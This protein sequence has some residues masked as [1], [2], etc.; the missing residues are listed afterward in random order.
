[1]SNQRAFWEW[2]FHVLLDSKASQG[3]HRKLKLR[4]VHARLVFTSFCIETWGFFAFLAMLDQHSE[5]YWLGGQPGRV[6]HEGRS[7]D[8]PLAEDLTTLARKDTA[9][10]TATLENVLDPSAIDNY[11]YP[12]VRSLLESTEALDT[13]VNEN[14]RLS[15]PV[16]AHVRRD[17][18]S[19]V[20]PMDTWAGSRTEEP[21]KSLVN[22][23]NIK[24]IQDVV[25]TKISAGTYE[26]PTARPVFSTELQ[27]GDWS[28]FEDMDDED[29]KPAAAT[30]DTDP[31]ADEEEV[32]CNGPTLCPLLR[33]TR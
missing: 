26:I 16:L 9:C 6:N 19:S 17:I 7:Y 15:L 5:L 25:V 12:S 24:Q 14:N 11:G 2:T 10:Y 22:N 18:M 8:G 20:K 4:A 27:R 30:E 31:L 28:D 33:L 1:M 23:Y 29:E 3:N 32:E 21:W 13:K